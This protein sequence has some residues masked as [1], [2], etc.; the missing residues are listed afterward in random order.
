MALP[1]SSGWMPVIQRH[2]QKHLEMTSSIVDLMMTLI[3]THNAIIVCIGHTFQFKNI[4]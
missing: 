2:R 3:F 4:T 1:P